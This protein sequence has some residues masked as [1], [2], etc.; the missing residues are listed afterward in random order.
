MSK[1]IFANMVAVAVMIAMAAPA[2]AAESSSANYGAG[3]S[4]E[5]FEFGFGV[6][7][8]CENAPSPG[9]VVARVG[10]NGNTLTLFVDVDGVNVFTLLRPTNN[11]F[12]TRTIE[13]N[14]CWDLFFS[15]EIR[16]NSIVSATADWIEKE[17]VCVTCTCVTLVNV[18]VENIVVDYEWRENQGVWRALTIDFDLVLV[19]S[20]GSERIIPRTEN[21]VDIGDKEGSN[22]QKNVTVNTMLPCGRLVNTSAVVTYDIELSGYNVHG[23]VTGVD[24]WI[25]TPSTFVNVCDWCFDQWLSSL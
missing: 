18:Y 2:M 17:C 3:V 13:Y 16:G 14:D 8:G 4:S 9:I 12:T 15:V 21:R 19:F 23:F 10:G 24:A 7:D 11:A 6:T 25:R 5:T 1:R 22:I 20:D